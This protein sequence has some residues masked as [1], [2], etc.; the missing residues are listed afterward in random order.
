MAIT[1]VLHMSADFDNPINSHLKH[2]IDYIL[3]PKKMGEANLCAGINCMTSETFDEMMNTKKVFQKTGG[4]QGYQFILSL[5][6]G[7]GS[8]Q[9]MYE[10]ALRFA[11]KAFGGNYEAV[12]AVH[13]DKPRIHAH[14][15]LNSVNMITGHKFQYKKGD[16]KRIYQPITNELCREYGLSIVP[17]EYSRDPSNVPRNEYNKDIKFRDLIWQD[18]ESLLAAA[19]D[20]EHFIWLLKRLGYEVKD[21][22]HIS[23]RVPGMKRF[24][25][26][27]TIDD[28]FSKENLE[29]SIQSAKTDSP[30]FHERTS[31]PVLYGCRAGSYYQKRVYYHMRGI[32]V[33]DRYRFGYKAAKYYNDIL[34]MH[35]LQ[36]EYLF[37]C[38]NNI[39]SFEDLMEYC[40]NA[41]LRIDGIHVEQQAIY[42]KNAALKRKCETTADIRTYQIRHMENGER[43][44]A[45][46]SEAKELRKNLRIAER[47]M[48]YSINE[49]LI[50]LGIEYEHRDLSFDLSVTDVPE[51]EKAVVKLKD[52][53]VQE[54][55]EEIKEMT[56]EDNNQH[57]VEVPEQ[58]VLSTNDN[59]LDYICDVDDNPDMVVE[60]TVT[61][62]SYSAMTDKEKAEWAGVTEDDF[63]GSI[64]RFQ[65]KMNELGIVYDSIPDMT[66]DFMKLYNAVK[67]ER[68]ADYSAMNR[69]RER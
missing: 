14:I 37:L 29:L 52:K 9:E 15:I 28:K 3:Q 6:P 50:R 46:K 63:K 19:T 67:I 22:I 2:A 69:K 53:I 23:V 34:L 55:K 40:K 16:W 39:H 26:I 44:D 57:P 51:Y 12:I 61:K 59:Y 25:R 45:L 24:A 38:D 35:K 18:C 62:D 33:T 49:Y 17:A 1:K 20:T 47:H 30:D 10:I 32:R 8:P 27:D 60:N 42:R 48:A 65:D 5:K 21:G 43:L 7:E 54:E 66:D 13:T 64:K 41:S 56:N 36:E 4:R 11:E 68:V 58:K 31:D